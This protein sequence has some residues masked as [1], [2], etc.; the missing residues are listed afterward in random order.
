MKKRT[1][2]SIQV[3]N[4]LVM[5]IVLGSDVFAA[6]DDMAGSNT[7]V[8]IEMKTNVN[9][10]AQPESA[11][12]SLADAYQSSMAVA[13]TENLELQKELLVQ[14]NEVDSQAFGALFPTVSGSVTALTQAAPNTTT[15]QAISPANQNTVKFTADQPL[16]RGLRDFA[17]LRQKKFLVG[18]QVY[19]LLNSA[20]QLFYDV[21]TAYYNVLS[22][23]E[24]ERN[25]QIE[26]E[27]NNK[28][29]KELE[30]FYKIGRSQLTDVLTF[31]A[32]IAS[33][34]AQLATTRG[35]LE[36]AR[37]VLA[38]VT[39]WHR[40]TKLEDRETAIV[41]PGDVATYLAKI[42]DRADIQNAIANVQANDEGVP[43]A[44]GQHLPN[45]D[46]IGDFY[47]ARPGTLS[48]VN[49]DVQFTLSIPIFQGGV[50]QSQVRQ[51]QS[52]ARQYNL[53]LSQTRRTAEQEIRT[54]YDSLVA[55]QKQ[56]AALTELVEVS[57]KNSETEIQYYRKGLVTN[58]DVLTAITT[59]QDAQ[60]Q[61]DHQ[62][63]TVKLDTV[64]LQAATGQRKEINVKDKK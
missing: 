30:E 46:L 49:W 62:R 14:A 31:K 6:S 17:A 52:V 32:N 8:S 27:V 34:Q 58:L 4:I 1:F 35:Q 18:A 44:W 50:V 5:S 54:F 64:K 13:N 16:F 2:P 10:A 9:S 53:L 38:F 51:A 26:I 55:D 28:R 60:R 39:G 25:Y 29:L 63:Y 61:M 41:K 36:T 40:D 7:T 43:I 37:E 15:G 23:A 22:Y 24:D 59:Y 56:L 12:H 19:A 21:S 57:K 42:D 3:A 20:R 33:L 11:A 45:A 47:A 48:D